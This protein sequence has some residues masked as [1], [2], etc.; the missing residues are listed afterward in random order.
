MLVG[1]DL[2]AKGPREHPGSVSGP[3]RGSGTL[4]AQSPRKDGRHGKPRAAAPCP[5]RLPEPRGCLSP[6]PPSKGEGRGSRSPSACPYSWT[7]PTPGGCHTET[8][9]RP[10]RG[11]DGDGAARARSCVSAASDSLLARGQRGRSTAERRD[12]EGNWHRRSQRSQHLVTAPGR[13]EHRGSHRPGQRQRCVQG[14]CRARRLARERG[15]TEQLC[16][17]SWKPRCPS[18]GIS[19]QKQHS[20]TRFPDLP[21]D[22]SPAWA[23][24]HPP[25][26]P[27]TLPADRAGAAP[28]SPPGS[29]GTVHLQPAHPQCSVGAPAQ[30]TAGPP[31]TRPSSR[32]GSSHPST[33]LR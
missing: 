18:F 21:S 4:H 9:A 19:R 20:C 28:C 8:P 33:G 30:V 27:R 11:N 12:S 16:V 6:P 15:H 3:W 24:A 17:S 5:S 23:A 2:S 13:G 14:S 25:A 10:G 31:P 26:G 7:P 22:A 32:P 29:P 1:K